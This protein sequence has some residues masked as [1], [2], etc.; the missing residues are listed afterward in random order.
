LLDRC[1]KC[2]AENSGRLYCTRCWSILEP[3]TDLWLKAEEI[4]T[5]NDRV[6]LE[7]VRATGVMPHLAYEFMV[8]PKERKERE[9]LAAKATRLLQSES[10]RAL[11]EECAY[12]LSLNTLPEVYAVE[13]VDLPEAFTFGST[14]TPVIVLNSRLVRDITQ[15]ELRALL[16]HEMGHIKSGHLLYHSLA[17]RLVD[18]AQV[19]F[20]LMGFKMISTPL[21]LALLAWKRESEF[22]ADRAAVLVS[23]SPHDFVMMLAKVAG[24]PTLPM[25][26]DSS[27]M[28]KAAA[29]FHSHPTLRERAKAAY[30]FSSGSE[31]AAIV[32]KCDLRRT[33]RG[34][35]ST[36]CRFCGCRK[37][38]SAVFCPQCGKSQV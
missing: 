27:L 20:S 30:E 37:E 12:D 24:T 28:E 36:T 32:R 14:Q 35:L 18:G 13:G 22:T 15:S 11:I 25:A 1:P 33:F 7:A 31:F 19:S 6:A 5:S 2:Q 38:V 17:E 9:L 3:R 16:G 34:A 8:K 21:R 23:R 10:Q 4:Q 29:I 26:S